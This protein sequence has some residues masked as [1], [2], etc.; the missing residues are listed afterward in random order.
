MRGRQH[1]VA[2][3]QSKRQAFVYGVGIG[4][5]RVTTPSLPGTEPL[6][7]SHVRKAKLALNISWPQYPYR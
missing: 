2:D 6:G 5:S 1:G 4:S 7:Y 3:R